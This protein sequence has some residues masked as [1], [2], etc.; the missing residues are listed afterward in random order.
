MSFYTKLLGGVVVLVGVAVVLVLLFF[1]GEEGAIEELLKGGVKAAERQDA[2]GVIALLSKSYQAPGQ[3]YAQA[4]ERVRRELKRIE[5][6]MTL[7]LEGAQIQV[8]GSDADAHVTVRFRVGTRVV[9][10]VVLRLH[11]KKEAEGWK[12]TSAEEVL[13]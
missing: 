10:D 6:G 5:R 11:L 2:E 13:R 7:D 12:V 3:D 9:G 1:S 4:C 8:A